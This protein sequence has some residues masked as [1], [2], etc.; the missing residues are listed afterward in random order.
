MG[1]GQ[2]VVLLDGGT[3]TELRARGVEV[4]SHVTSIWSAQALLEAPDAVVEVHRAYA[5]AGADVITANNYAVTA[6]LLS[7]V[8]LEDRVEELTIRAVELAQRA[9]DTSARPVRIAG[10]LPPL[11]TS[12]RADLVGSDEAILAG[13]RQLAA[14]L[15]PRVDLLLCETL[16]SAREATAAAMAARETGV[17]FWLSLTLQGNQVD[18]LPS[19]ESL[20]E[21]VGAVEH[22]PVEALLLNC[23]GANLVTQALATLAALGDRPRGGYAHPAD[24]DLGPSGAPP[25]RLEELRYAPLDVEGYAT[26]V[27]SW[28]AAGATIVGGCCQTRPAHVARLRRLIDERA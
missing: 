27:E 25:A 13:Y 2:S 18:R 14:V 12:Y 23:C 7:R 1:A 26:V 15:A 4:P 8:G 6:P 5:D 19:G 10:S 11:D 22:L 28:L 20:E 16:A 9:R 3:G 24:V 17:P 21:A